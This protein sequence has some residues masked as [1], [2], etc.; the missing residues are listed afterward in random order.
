MGNLVGREHAQERQ[1]GFSCRTIGNSLLDRETESCSDAFRVF[2][3]LGLFCDKFCGTI[4]VAIERNA[5]KADIGAGVIKREWQ[6][7]K[8]LGEPNGPSAIVASGEIEQ[9]ARR[10]HR[11][12]RIDLDRRCPSGPLC[13]SGRDKKMSPG[14]RYEIANILWRSD[15]VV[16]EQPRP[17]AFGQLIERT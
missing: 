14:A 8:S 3:A 10:F 1:H 2:R 17:R 7:S 13:P 4:G 12:E 15:I 5:R 11:L 9:K 6:I 16:D